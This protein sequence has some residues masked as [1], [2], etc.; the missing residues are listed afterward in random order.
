MDT[1]EQVDDR[2]GRRVGRRALLIEHH[3][4]ACCCL[5]GRLLGLVGGRERS[6]LC[7]RMYRVHQ[8]LPQ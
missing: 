2:T 4:Q 6:C 1:D 7:R 8:V 5:R 3:R